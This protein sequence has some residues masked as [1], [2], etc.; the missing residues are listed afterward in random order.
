MLEYD[1]IFEKFHVGTA[2]AAVKSVPVEAG[3]P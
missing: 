3:A 1:S 2:D